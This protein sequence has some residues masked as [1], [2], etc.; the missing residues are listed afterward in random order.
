MF[1]E[2]R[3]NQVDQVAIDPCGNE[4]RKITW[5]ATRNHAKGNANL[6]PVVIN[7]NSQALRGSKK[8]H[9]NSPTFSGIVTT[10]AGSWN[11]IARPYNRA[12]CPLSL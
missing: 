9:A 5:G 6:R 1:L 2:S 12:G 3:G 11:K 4:R 8:T 7:R 10:H